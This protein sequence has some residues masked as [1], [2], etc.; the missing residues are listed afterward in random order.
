MVEQST[1][2]SEA[3]RL[4]SLIDRFKIAGVSNPSDALHST[5]RAMARPSAETSA[6]LPQARPRMASSS[7]VASNSAAAQSWEEFQ[8][9]SLLEEPQKSLSS[10]GRSRA[11]PF[12]AH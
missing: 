1:A 8:G 3:G 6:K 5:A 9:A 7:A 11:L 2:A 10:P 12:M 4:R